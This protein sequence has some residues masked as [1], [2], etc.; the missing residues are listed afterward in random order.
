MFFDLT[1]VL[2]IVQQIA[3]NLFPPYEITLYLGQRTYQELFPQVLVRVH[4]SSELM[5]DFEGTHNVK[6]NHLEMVKGTRV[7]LCLQQFH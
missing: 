6:N 3:Y 7:Q 2:K 4:V 5:E 1:P